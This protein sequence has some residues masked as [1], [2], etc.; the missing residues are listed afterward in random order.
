[1]AIDTRNKRSSVINFDR[2]GRLFPN[3]DGSLANANDRIHIGTKYAGIPGAG[4]GATKKVPWH[5]FFRRV[6]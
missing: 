3:P 5:L 6:I 4:A 1:M 2:S